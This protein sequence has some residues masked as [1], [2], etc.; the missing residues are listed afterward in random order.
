[1]TPYRS[2]QVEESTQ[3]G[4][5]RREAVALAA[6][7][8]FD[9][10]RTGR[11][12][13]VVTE[14]GNNLVRHAT[15]G[16]CLVGV[17][18]HRHAHPCVE[19]LALDT[20][21]GMTSFETC[22][23]DGYSTAGTAGTGLGA[24]KRLA[25]EFAYFSAI[26]KGTVIA[27]R[28]GRAGLQAASSAPAFD[29]SGICLAAPGESQSGDAWAVRLSKQKLAVLVADGLGHGPAAAQASAA[30]TTVFEGLEAAP[31]A[32]LEKAHQALGSTRGAAVAV[33]E[34]DAEQGIVTFAGA[35]NVIGRLVSGVED[36]S[37][38]SQNGTVGLQIRQLKDIVYP[39]QEHSLFILHSDGITSRWSLAAVGGLL[40]CDPSVIAGWIIRDHCRGRDDATV[41][42][43][44]R[45]R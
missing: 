19:V 31:S 15:G 42:V 28:I 23:R 16:R 35:G 21:P 29:I 43:I 10:E 3:V 7:L 26:G 5:A 39:W 38:L 44:K 18:E 13:L 6:R 41:V 36:R 11:V 33:A 34:L 20:G 24:A 22:L 30:A 12:G 37:L 2:I 40:Q 27:A 25:D 9:E 14:L 45:T 1:V 4:A 17:A 32:I 8:G